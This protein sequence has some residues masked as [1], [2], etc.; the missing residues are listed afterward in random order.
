MC[1]IHVCNFEKYKFINRLSS[2]LKKINEY[3]PILH[4]IFV[5]D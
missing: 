4:Y 2:A 1:K 5:K 3:M